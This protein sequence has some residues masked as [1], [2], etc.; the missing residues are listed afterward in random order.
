M[1]LARRRIQNEAWLRQARLERL[2]QS[3]LFQYSVGR[4]A[5]LDRVVNEKVFLRVGAVSDFV[6]AFVLSV[7]MMLPCAE[8]VSVALSA[9][10]GS[11]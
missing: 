3:C 9:W 11:V 1:I 4:I 10:C 6:I 7:K 2:R 8:W 5:R